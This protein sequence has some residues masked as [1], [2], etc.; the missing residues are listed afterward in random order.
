[1]VGQ[2]EERQI[3]SEK[4]IYPPLIVYPEGGSTNGTSLIQFKK[5]A[6]TGLKSIKPII[7][8]YHSNYIDPE[9]CVTHFAAQSLLS[10]VAPYTYLKI[11]ELPVFVP[12][13][14]FFKN[15]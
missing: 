6:F 1:M 3:E 8:R 12:N 15:H 10:G 2:I 7:I 4:R 9:N 11:K 14:Y 13:E 5:G